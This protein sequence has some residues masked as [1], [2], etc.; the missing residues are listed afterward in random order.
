M[1]SASGTALGT[2]TVND[3]GTFSVTLNPA[4]LNGQVLTLSQTDDA[5]NVSG[6]ATYQVPD[7]T[8]PAPVD[9]LAVSLNGLVLTGTGE[10]GATVTV[11]FQGVAL[12]SATVA[13][14]GRF[15][16]DLS[17]AQL[18]GQ[19]LSVVQV[20]AGTNDST[21]VNVSAPDITP[22]HCRPSLTWWTALS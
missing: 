17:T 4:Q 15:S 8:D 22:P 3:D 20:D 10:A 13:A 18:N 9:N 2:A 21:P 12:G 7:V 1:T 16:V 5:T 19:L 6:N 14:D 11:S